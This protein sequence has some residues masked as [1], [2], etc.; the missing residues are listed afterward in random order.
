[1]MAQVVSDPPPPLRG[2]YPDVPAGL[3]RVLLRGLERDRDRRPKNLE[4]FRAALL[5]FAPERSSAGTPG[6]RFAAHLLD[7][8]LFALFG[9]DVGLIALFAQQDMEPE[10]RQALLLIANGLWILCFTLLEGLWGWS[11][12]KHLL[13]LRVWAVGDSASRPGAGPGADGGP[14]CDRLPGRDGPAVGG[15]RESRKRGG[16]NW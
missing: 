5:P 9:T 8:F 15:V 16:W 6:W 12:G 3:E 2:Q 13:G 10:A 1:M 4:E 7:G 11:P 14:L